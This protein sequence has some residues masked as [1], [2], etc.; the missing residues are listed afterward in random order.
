[1]AKPCRLL[2]LSPA[3]RNADHARGYR[4]FGKKMLDEILAEVAAAVAESGMA[5]FDHHLIFGGFFFGQGEPDAA[6]RSELLKRVPSSLVDCAVYRSGEG[7]A[8]E[9]AQRA[10]FY[11]AFGAGLGGKRIILAC[12]DAC[13]KRPDYP[14]MRATSDAALEAHLWNDL[15]MN[16]FKR[17][18]K[19]MAE[20][21]S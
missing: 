13:G 6:L 7:A 16:A 5:D 18:G 9:A 8:A 3:A 15:A 14:H 21:Q 17:I 20:R 1:M 2:V 4:P 11:F 12:D 19:L 10:L